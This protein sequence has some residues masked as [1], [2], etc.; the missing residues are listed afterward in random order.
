MR[1]TGP[2]TAKGIMALLDNR[3]YATRARTN[4]PQDPP[5]LTVTRAQMNALEKHARESFSRPD[6]TFTIEGLKYKGIRLRVQ[7]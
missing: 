4:P 5:S 2:K 6:S 1:S 7:G 3:I